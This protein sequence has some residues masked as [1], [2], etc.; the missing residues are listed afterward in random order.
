MARLAIIRQ[1]YNPAGGAERFVSQAL[2]QLHQQGIDLTLITRQW[3]T[4]DHIVV[5]QLNPFYLGSLWRDWSFTRAVKD[6]L[7]AEPYDLI[8]SHE[9]IPECTIYR[10]GDGLHC[11]WLKERQRLLPFWK[12]ILLRLN[13]YHH[14]VCHQEDLLFNSP[15]LQKIICNSYM[16]KDEICHYFPTAAHK[17]EVIYNGVDFNKFNLSVTQH[18]DFIRRQLNIPETSPTLVFVGSGFERKGLAVA[19]QAIESLSHI[20]L[21]VVGTDKHLRQF[22]QLADLNRIHFV[23]RQPDVRPY[24]GAADGF[25]L[26]T[27]Y[28]P[29][30]NA[31]LEALACGLPVLTSTKCGTR[32]LINNNTGYVCDAL[33]VNGFREAIDQWQSTS[34]SP[35]TI[36]HSVCHLSIENMTEQL[37]KIYE[38]LMLRVDEAR[39]V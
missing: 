3:H 22:Q 7:K 16:V 1:K 15:Q 4:L 36:H 19:L 8:Q 35:E 27:L 29:F 20:H 28:D 31:A 14:F 11:V 21:I 25:I 9:R 38:E 37:L 12:K 5:I 10:A 24:L 33:D 39:L 26:P 30:P 2:Q 18:R 6:H 32:E 34:F 17:I 13:P 23:G